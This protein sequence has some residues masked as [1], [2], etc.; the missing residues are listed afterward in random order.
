MTW[1]KWMERPSCRWNMWTVK[2][3][4]HCS[5]VSDVCPPDKGLEIARKLCAG[6]RRPT[7]KGYSIAI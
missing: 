5:A 4:L 6:W 2:I 7:K 3:S 1:E